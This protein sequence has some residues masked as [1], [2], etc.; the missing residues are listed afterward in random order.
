MMPDRKRNVPF[1][2]RVAREY[3]YALGLKINSSMSMA[4]SGPR[5]M[6]VS[7]WSTRLAEPSFAD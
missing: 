2:M 5:Q 6:M 3:S 4:L 7:S 1:I